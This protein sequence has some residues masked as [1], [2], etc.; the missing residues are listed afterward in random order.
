MQP[1]LAARY[2]LHFCFAPLTYTRRPHDAALFPATHPLPV[3]TRVSIDFS[4]SLDGGG[5]NSENDEFQGT[6]LYV[7][8]MAEGLNSTG[9]AKRLRPDCVNV[10]E[11][12]SNSR[13]KIHQTWPRPFS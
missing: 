12:V 1:P 3:I 10:A 5:P 4:P 11:V 2:I 7:A 13:N 9:L 8:E 6:I